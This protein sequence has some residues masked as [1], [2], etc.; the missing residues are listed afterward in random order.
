M[1]SKKEKPQ[2]IFGFPNGNKIIF[3]Y[4]TMEKL[5]F[6]MKYYLPRLFPNHRDLLKKK[7]NE[8]YQ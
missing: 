7:L 5:A 1:T 6:D 2:I 3:T 4:D 8:L